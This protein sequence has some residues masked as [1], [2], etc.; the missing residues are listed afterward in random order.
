[1]IFSWV[2][3]DFTA[4]VHEMKAAGPRTSS[5]LCCLM[6]IAACMLPQNAIPPQEPEQPPRAEHCTYDPPRSLYIAADRVNIRSGP[7]KVHA[8]VASGRKGQLVKATG[9]TSQWYCTRLKSGEGYIYESLVTDI[10]P[11]NIARAASL[12]RPGILQDAAQETD[13]QPG[14]QNAPAARRP[15]GLKPG[16]AIVSS[17]TPASVRAAASPFA[18]INGELAPGAD[19]TILEVRGTWCRILSDRTEGFVTANLLAQ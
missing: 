10:K 19:V 9:K 18:K 7:G 11:D 13:S 12:E 16:K 3:R 5:F 1:M 17:L 15:A 4:L 2:S 6:C 14:P 8:V